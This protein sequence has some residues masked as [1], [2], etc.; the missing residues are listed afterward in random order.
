M[1][2]VGAAIDEGLEA[3]K[4][5]FSDSAITARVKKRF[6]R[7]EQVSAFDIR[8]ATYDGLVILE[9]E[10][11]SEDVAQRA[12]DIAKATKGVKNVENRIW[13]VRKA[14]SRAR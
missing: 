8:V 13:I 4:E 9:G 6:V 14:P 10:A 7:D 2:R 5:F 12:V 11:P 1:E 3:T